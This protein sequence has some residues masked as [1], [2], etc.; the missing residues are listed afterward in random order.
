MK[1]G[2]FVRGVRKW[3][4]VISTLGAV[5]SWLSRCRKLPELQESLS[6]HE[7]CSNGTFQPFAASYPRAYN[8][9]W[10]STNFKTVLAWDP[11]PSDLY[12]YTVEFFRWVKKQTLIKRV[13]TEP[14]RSCKWQNGDINLLLIQHRSTGRRI[15]IREERTL[16]SSYFYLSGLV[17]TKWGTLIV[18]APH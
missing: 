12:S 11:K 7:S 18:S 13:G 1:F 2:L 15:R 10:K 5:C 3:G 9:T 14:G 17:E 6:I 8:V 16:N 4:R